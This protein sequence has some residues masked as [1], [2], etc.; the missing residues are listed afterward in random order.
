MPNI[1]HALVIAA[2]AEKVYDS[3]TGAGGLSAWW[4]PGSTAK[5]EVNSIARFPF[6]SEYY[7]EM[8]IEKLE[9]G[10]LIKWKCLSGD[11]QWI[12]T[13]ITF[14]IEEGDAQSLVQ[15]HPEIRG[16][17]QQLKK[18]EIVSLLIFN[19]DNWSDQ[20]LMLAE[21]NFTWAMFLRSLKLFCET[22]KGRPWPDQ[23]K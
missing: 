8:H 18:V 6:G 9:P 23:H 1:Y 13:M 22:G 20:T 4:T 5:S 15:K 14:R 7:K 10:R 17:I 16:Q 2:P 19:H 11:A 12:D 3:I 21:C